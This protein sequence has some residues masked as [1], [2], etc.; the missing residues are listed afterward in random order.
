[1][2]T[3]DQAVRVEMTPKSSLLSTSSC[4]LFNNRWMRQAMKQDSHQI[5]NRKEKPW[6]RICMPDNLKLKN[7]VSYSCIK[8]KAI[9]QTLKTDTKALTFL[10]HFAEHSIKQRRFFRV[11][12]SMM[13]LLM[14]A[15][16]LYKYTFLQEVLSLA[17]QSLVI[18]LS[19]TTSTKLLLV[20]LS[21]LPHKFL[22]VAPSFNLLLCGFPVKSKTSITHDI[23]R[24]L[25][26][27]YMVLSE[28][29]D[30]VNSCCQRM[31]NC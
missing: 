14:N 25:P 22:K 16:I 4:L 13:S 11:C 21:R 31:K 24:C 23:P 10:S 5:V 8:D 18:Y 30:C 12:K 15:S 26:R 28:P 2:K 17:L 20:L 7:W 3:S 1:M 6:K 29:T 9:S 27:I 19:A